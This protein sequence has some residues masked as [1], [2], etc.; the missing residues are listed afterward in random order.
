MGGGFISLS[1]FIGAVSSNVEPDQVLARLPRP[2]MDHAECVVISW[3]EEHH[4][5]SFA[6]LGRV[7]K[8]SRF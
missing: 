7:A 8:V 3:F 2:L 5:V 1:R 6:D 4:S